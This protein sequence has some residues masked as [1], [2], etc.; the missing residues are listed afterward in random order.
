MHAQ[1]D[2]EPAVVEHFAN[3]RIGSTTFALIENDKLDAR[4]IGHQ[5][6]FCFA[7]NPGDSRVRPGVLNRANDGKC[8]TRI[9]NRRKTN[10][11]NTVGWRLLKHLCKPETEAMSKRN[12]RP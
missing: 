3:V 2:I 7:D 1:C 8:M 11:T 6:S 9:A 5:S 10:D 4:N 12:V